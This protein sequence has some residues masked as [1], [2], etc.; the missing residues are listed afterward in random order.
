MA[1]AETLSTD[2]EALSGEYVS[3]EIRD[4]NVSIRLHCDVV[5]RL[6][7]EIVHGLGAIP[8]RGAEV[9]GVLLGRA[10]LSEKLVVTVE[11]FEL[12][13]C[14]YSRGP[15]F[16]LSPEEEA[17]FQETVVRWSPTP[18]RSVYAVG[19]F[20][21]HT[22]EGL[23]LSRED[24]ALFDTLFPRPTDIV[25]LVK[26][27]LGKPS[28]A[29]FFFREAGGVMRTES[30]YMEFSFQRSETGDPYA[31]RRDR[32]QKGAVNVADSEPA[33]SDRSAFSVAPKEASGTETRVTPPKRKR[34]NVWIPLSFLFLV[35]GICLG[36]SIGHL[37]GI[38]QRSQEASAAGD[39]Y[40]LSLSAEKSGD[41]VRVKWN[42]RAPALGRA[43]RAVLHIQDGSYSNSVNIEPQDLPGGSLFYKNLT[44]EVHFKLEVF[45]DEHASVGE[46]VE[47]KTDVFP[48]AAQ[49]SK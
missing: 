27:A 39:P 12:V 1:R 17:Q 36:M 43:R 49:P 23:G 46:S 9:G 26:P 32:E 8:R 14:S 5:D 33:A 18:D 7:A 44:G 35:L 13:A 15:S 19:Y 10:V 42:R 48:R 21:S 38:I 41:A 29:G 16:L 45:V 6:S 34:G 40:R 22:R 3:W 31:Q 2:P 20:R 11:D 24:L 47:Y 4:K 28:V 25:L 37:L 30:P